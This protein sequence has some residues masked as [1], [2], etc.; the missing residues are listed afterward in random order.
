M[1][2]RMRWGR[3]WREG[4]RRR[5]HTPRGLTGG[6]ARERGGEVTVALWSSRERKNA[7]RRERT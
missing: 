6:V 2:G 3:A 1:T 5:R 4:R 7:R